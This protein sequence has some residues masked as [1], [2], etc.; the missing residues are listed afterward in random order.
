MI[1]TLIIAILV[2]VL[3]LYLIQ[4]AP[5][6]PTAMRILQIGVVIIALLWLVN[7]FGL[8]NV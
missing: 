5:L 6:E 4:L 2:L 8:A 7:H 1:V 3:L